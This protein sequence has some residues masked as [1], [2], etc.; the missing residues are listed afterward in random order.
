MGSERQ[1]D[2]EPT[3]C[4]R[5]GFFVCA[6]LKDEKRRISLPAAQTELFGN[7]AF[8]Q[9]SPD[10][11]QIMGGSGLLEGS[12]LPGLVNDAMASRLFSGSS[13]ILK[14]IIAGL[15]GISRKEA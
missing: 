5:P 13:E 8:L 12:L 10:A 14:N 1:R 7:E 9:S 4:I 3:A 15:S 11:V 2:S 6:W